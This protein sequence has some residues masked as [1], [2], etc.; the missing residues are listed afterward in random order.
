MTLIAKPILKNKLW[1]VTDNGIKVGNVEFNNS[2]YNLKIGNKEENFDS[3]AAIKK[4]T[5]IE[6]L[7]PKKQPTS[8]HLS[9]AKWPT[10][11]KTYNDIFDVK[12]RLH[13]FTKTKKSKCFYVAGWFRINVNNV[14]QTMFCPKYIFITRYNYEGPFTSQDELNSM[15]K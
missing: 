5:N 1:V 6:F 10:G 3:T 12:R 4:L 11:G 2:T 14:W 9:Y 8:K 7:R 13:I 15:T